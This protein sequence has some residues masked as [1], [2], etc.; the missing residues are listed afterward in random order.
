MTIPTVSRIPTSGPA[1][2]LVA[3]LISCYVVSQFLRNSI[4]VIAPNLATELVLSPA[5]IGLL[6]SVFFFS[7]AAVQVPLGMALDRFGARRCLLVGA[8]ITVAGTVVF[9]TA[10]SPGT[11]IFGRALMG[12][13]VAGALVAPL[14]VYAKRFRPER[15]A[16]LTGLHAGIGTAGTLIATAPLAF[17]TAT[18]GWRNSFLA[19]AAFTL[20]TGILIVAVVAD[21]APAAKS[22]RE[23]LRESVSGIA[24]VLRPPSLGRLCAMNLVIYSSFALIVGLWGGPYLTHIYGYDLEERGDFLVIPVLTQMIGLIA[25]GP[26]DRLMGSHKRPVLLGA[27]GTALMLAYLALNERL[28]PFGL[29]AWFAAFGFLAAFGP[30]LLAHGK[31][32]FPPH[33]VGR[34]LTI[35][36]TASMGGT[37]L[38][39]A[40]SGLVIGQFPT[41]QDGA[42]ALA[43]YRWVFG[44]QAGIILL[45]CLIYFGSQDPMEERP[46]DH[47]SRV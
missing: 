3:T 46:P 4:G 12:L 19:I 9:A 47:P 32:I 17:A 33:Q 14:A 20:L 45:M 8:A 15:F 16:T 21:D 23:T 27:G 30:V 34:G 29:V 35:L 39:Q 44:L 2:M 1:I 13:G 25:W 5:E 22:R 36:N 37:F 11:L 18:I 26:M 28:T 41:T 6:S 7:F 42:Y 24:D 43:G 38:F 10:P 31:A 40:I